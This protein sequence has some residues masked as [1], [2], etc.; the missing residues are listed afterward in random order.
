MTSGDFR[1]VVQTPQA[2]TDPSLAI[3]A[4]RAGH[5]GILGLP[6][7]AGS[8]ACDSVD[9][10][11]AGARGAFGL[12]VVD[13]REESVALLVDAAARGAGWAVVSADAALA[14]PPVLKRL[15]KVG[16]RVLIET[17]DWHPGLAGL[18]PC[19]GIIVKGHEAGGPVGEQT[20]F[21]LVQKLLAQSG[22]PVY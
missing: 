8:P 20:G 15:G 17:T 16:L 13:L 5:I 9:R 22:S 2:A 18:A 21:I 4:A 12:A 1:I 11:C 19:D 3:A 6:R 10:L 14:D 7:A